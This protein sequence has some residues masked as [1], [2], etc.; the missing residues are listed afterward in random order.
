M[1]FFAVILFLVRALG[2]SVLRTQNT[3]LFFPFCRFGF[4]FLI[5]IDWFSIVF[6]STL[7]TIC[8]S[9]LVFRKRYLANDSFY[10]RFVRLLLLFIV[11]MIFII[12]FPQTVLVLLGW[13][14]LGLFR[15][16]LVCF[17]KANSRWRAGFKTFLTNRIGDS[18]F[19]LFL[20]R[21]FLPKSLWFKHEV[22]YSLFISSYFFLACFTKSAQIPFR[23]WLPA[24]MA[25]PTP[26]S[27]LV[28]SSTLVTA[29]V[30]LLFRSIIS[31]A[32]LVSEQV[33]FLSLC[34]SLFAAIA[35]SLEWDSKKAVAFSTLSN[36]GIMVLSLGLN[37]FI[38]RFF[39]LVTHAVSKAL[40]FICVGLQ[41]MKTLHH[42]DFRFLNSSILSSSL[43][44]ICAVYSVFRLS[45]VV[46]FRGFFSKETVLENPLILSNP[47]VLLFVRLILLFSFYYRFRILKILF[48]RINPCV[49]SPLP[50]TPN[51]YSLFPLLICRILLGGVFNQRFSSS[52][53]ISPLVKR[54]VYFFLL[55]AIFFLTQFKFVRFFPAKEFFFLN[56][57]GS[58]LPIGMRLKSSAAFN[59]PNKTLQSIE[60]ST[61]NTF[62]I[63]SYYSNS[64]L[65]FERLIMFLVILALLY[66]SESFRIPYLH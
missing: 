55:S 44:K 29:G 26:V 51:I 30:Y 58:S 50:Q 39:H 66:F 18:F 49:V 13:D 17:Y 16:L 52:W 60:F 2:Y 32:D 59:T 56:F 43:T 6:L 64:F 61:S 20:A 3:I 22:A 57:I 4:D 33:L 1:D 14:G 8:R 63:L 37:L 10:S 45:G 19:I 15:F 41:M 48:S 7:F 35:A 38:Q 34:T 25:A 27:A 42:Q 40:L 62:S 24:A 54:V 53:I 21:I 5:L 9:V 31:W 47:T 23:S 11:R 46:F 65:R 12:I 36:L 28:H